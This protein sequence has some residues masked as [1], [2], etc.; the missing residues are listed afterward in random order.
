MTHVLAIA[1]REIRERRMVFVAAAFLATLP[2][3]FALL[4]S[5]ARFGR[6]AR[7]AGTGGILASAW[8]VGLAIVLGVSILSSELAQRRLSFYLTKPIGAASVWLGKLT[9][10]WV[11]VLVTFAIVFVPSLM[12]GGSAWQTAWNTPIN[13]VVALVALISLGLILLFHLAGTFVRSRSPLLAVDLVLG[14]L[15]AGATWLLVQPLMARLSLQNVKIVTLG[16]ACGFAAAVIPAGVFQVARGR[17]DIRASHAA[18]SKFVWAASAV[19]LLFGGA[20]VA[21]VLSAGPSDLLSPQLGQASA[22]KWAWATG[23]A[24]K[25]NDY[26]PLFLID[27]TTGRHFSIPASRFAASFSGDGNSAVWLRRGNLELMVTRLGG[28]KPRHIATGLSGPW[29]S[30]AVLSDDGTRLAAID[31]NQTLSVSDVDGGR[32][33]ASVKLAGSFKSHRMFFADNDTVR[34]YETP[35][36][37]AQPGTGTTLRAYELNI[38]GRG[39]TLTGELAAPAKSLMLTADSSGRRVLLMPNGG[40]GMFLLDGR[41]LQNMAT[42]SV[43][44]TWAGSFILRNGNVVIADRAAGVLGVFAGSGEK[45]REIRVG[46]ASQ[47]WAMSEI[48]PSRLVVLL[49]GRPGSYV[50]DFTTLVVD[51]ERGVIER[52]DKVMPAQIRGYDDPRVASSDAPRQ[53]LVE[54][55]ERRLWRWNPLTGAKT[56]L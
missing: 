34:I 7:I 36:R 18:L 49:Y 13:V 50:R 16:V 5:A 10:A 17:A 44:P 46:H 11:I 6:A 31:S 14:V 28:G 23:Q 42:Y 51:C 19:V 20:F 30:V 52:R 40:D 43:K 56:R 39:L 53:L 4:P 3:L 38:P 12:V 25:R 24:A 15:F 8:A 54:D 2:F 29:F 27:T 45:L 26:R 47:I 35:S 32:I 22:G 1:S 33:L 41:S 37:V 9:A 21:W 55:A 48:A